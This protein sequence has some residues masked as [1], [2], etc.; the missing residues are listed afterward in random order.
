MS[1][2]DTRGGGWQA[3]VMTNEHG[4]RGD[5]VRAGQPAA[6]RWPETLREFPAIRQVFHALCAMGEGEDATELLDFA[7]R[8]Q[9]MADVAGRF[10]TVVARFDDTMAYE[11]E[12]DGLAETLWQLY[13]ASRVRDVLFLAHQPVPA[14]D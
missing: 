11:P 5:A 10:Q 14:D 13:A 2:C 7:G 1:R 8:Q 3:G 4:R 6:R 9:W 12:D